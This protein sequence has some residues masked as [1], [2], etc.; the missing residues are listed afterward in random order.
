MVLFS[1][2]SVCVFQATK[3]LKTFVLMRLIVGRF[4]SERSLVEEETHT[5]AQIDCKMNFT[6]V[7]K[8]FGKSYTVIQ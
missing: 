5:G 2:L 1:S 8:L 6:C 3:N 4:L 7:D